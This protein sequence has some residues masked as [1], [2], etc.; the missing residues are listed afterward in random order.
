[1]LNA[2]HGHFLEGC[3][4]RIAAFFGVAL[5]GG[6]G[7][8]L[9]VAT[10]DAMAAPKVPQ[11]NM[12]VELRVVSEDQVQ[13]ATQDSLAKGSTVR[14]QPPQDSEPTVQKVFV[15]N[16]ER[17]QLQLSQSMPVQWVK[18]AVQQT[19]TTTAPS[20]AVTTADARGVENAVTWLD[21]AQS[22]QVLVRWPGGRAAAV[23]EVEVE[24]AAVD[25][26]QGTGRRPAQVQAPGALPSQSRSKLA[27]KVAVPLGEWTTIGVTGVRVAPAAAGAYSSRAAE[28]STVRL[29]QVRVLAP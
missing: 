15:M 2:S 14:T 20:G 5:L 6:V 24:G 19:G 25:D 22:L 18:S 29:M 28:P 27:T 11:R 3:Y 13:P 16:G 7:A 17:A 4:M 9:G 12:T 26:A 10:M 1:M 21:A 8:A 23:L